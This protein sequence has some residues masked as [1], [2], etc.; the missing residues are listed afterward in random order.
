MSPLAPRVSRIWLGW[1]ALLLICSVMLVLLSA[2]RGAE[3]AASRQ[4]QEQEAVLQEI[5]RSIASNLERV[6]AMG[7]PLDEAVGMEPWLASQTSAS[8]L[9]A[10]LALSLP[11]GQMLAQ[12]G[13]DPIV[14]QRLG[15]RGPDNSTGT[16]RPLVSVA[17]KNANASQTTAW[18]HVL[19]TPRAGMWVQMAGT[20]GLAFAVSAA[21]ALAL[22]AWLRRR[23]D[24]SLSHIELHLTQMASGSLVAGTVSLPAPGQHEVAL[25]D[26]ALAHHWQ[27]LQLRQAQL[28]QKLNEVRAAH[29][30]SAVLARIDTMATPLLCES[31][32]SIGEAGLTPL[33]H[34]RWQNWSLNRR[35]SAILLA[36]WLLT[37][38][39]LQGLHGLNSDRFQHSQTQTQM[40]RLQVALDHRITQDLA[41]LDHLVQ[42]AIAQTVLTSGTPLVEAMLPTAAHWWMRTGQNASWEASGSGSPLSM[43]PPHT[44]QDDLANRRDAVR[45]IWV[46]TES[47]KL[48]LGTGKAIA[49]AD[50]TMATLIASQP[51][52]VTLESLLRDLGGHFALADHRGQAVGA[53]PLALIKRWQDAGRL[54]V[55]PHGP[56]DAWLLSVPLSSH[57]GHTL[58]HLVVSVPNGGW[59]DDAHD[60]GQS[61]LL[62]VLGLLVLGA[63]AWLVYQQLN[64]LGEA[65]RA[66][67]QLADTPDHVAP[68]A[69]Q[70]DALHQD[71]ARV[72]NR[73]DV[74]R[75]LRRSRERQ[76]RRQARFIRHQMLELANR[77]DETARADVLK[78]L[79]RIEFASLHS[80]QVIPDTPTTE[81]NPR[82]E[83][84]A[85]EVGVLALGFQNLVGRVGD[86]YQQLGHLVQ[87]LREALRVKTQFIAIQQELEIARKM[88]LS[89][90][91]HDFSNQRN[92][93]LHGMTQPAREVGGDFYDF[94]R[95]DDDH[96][97]V[98][99][100]DVSGKGVPAAFFMAVS[101]TLLR[102]VAQFST[103]PADC[104]QRLNDLLAADNEELMFV[105]LFYAV[106]DTRDG[107]VVY[108]NAGHNPPYVVRS[109]GQIEV[110]PILGDMALA[111]MP[112]MPY[113][114]QRLQ[115][116][117]G[118]ALFLY[119]DGVTEAANPDG[120]WY[121]EPL[122]ETY[123]QQQATKGSV[124]TVNHGL[125]E[126]VKQFEAGGAQ[127][128]DVTCL[129]VR[130]TPTADAGPSATQ[131]ATS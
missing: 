53:D 39:T 11:S 50:G 74:L 24:R 64:P 76:G 30:D 34:S 47:H 118:D 123:L 10:G 128:D 102:A 44:V 114:E 73:L 71:I 42:P 113:A 78:D 90:L 56:T 31:P 106:I 104:L 61:A 5:G 21:A 38:V 126:S 103:C 115:L 33:S 84:M 108:S 75:A 119:T 80:P 49:L 124:E 70:L 94:F 59:T 117:P 60:N 100:A 87:E 67:A 101:R 4:Q 66:I 88:Q 43:P 120:Q 93:Q 37:W 48:R 127:S 7:I 6:Q 122:L 116:A 110:I 77:L 107:S 18:L 35:V 12:L 69:L 131:Q 112:D 72:E 58:G 9:V 23:V 51:L 46:G 26:Q 98:L 91:P 95:L 125:I 52:N 79:E 86:Q 81:L 20:L 29:F 109:N 57:S 8:P 62:I 92:V 22:K 111:V 129:M 105:T 54:P 45:G 41:R 97:S 83:R 55:P 19:G 40:R 13:M 3:V 36:G 27:A 14:L 1:S 89:F 15:H 2:W 82:F 68:D 99:V 25:L 96:L 32:N 85:D 63:L 65:A 28:L 130:F 17:V 121:G 16:D